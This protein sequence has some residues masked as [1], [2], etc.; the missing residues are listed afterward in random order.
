MLGRLGT[1]ISGF[2]NLFQHPNLQAYVN[3]FLPASVLPNPTWIDPGSSF[4]AG[5]FLRYDLLG[6]TGQMNNVDSEVLH[7]IFPNNPVVDWLYQLQQGSNYQF[8]AIGGLGAYFDDLLT[9]VAYMTDFNPANTATSLNLPLTYFSGERALMMTRSDWSTNALMLNMHTREFNGGHPEDDRNS[10]YIFGAGR[11]W[12]AINQQN[13]YNNA[14]S[15]VDI[16]APASTT[17]PIAGET[18]PPLQGVATPGRMVD[19]QD[20]PYATFAVGDASYCWDYVDTAGNGYTPAEIAAGDF[21]LPKGSVLEPHSKN[22]FA[23]TKLVSDEMNTPLSS[24]P[25]WIEYNGNIA[26]ITRVPLFA[27]PIVKAFRTTGLVRGPSTGVTPYGLVVDDI[28]VST[29]VAHHYDWQLLLVNDVQIMNQTSLPAS[30]GVYDIT[31]ATNGVANPGDPALLIRVLDMNTTCTISPC[32][33]YIIPVSSTNTR[34]DSYR[35]IFVIPS[36]SVSP[37]FKVLIFPYTIG[38]PIPT[39]TWNAAHT[40][41]TVTMPTYSDTITFSPAASGKT[42]VNIMRGGQTVI[43]MNTPIAPFQ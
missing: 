16:D 14:Q 6:G 7:Y 9:G 2:Q 41:V 11:G 33:P 30:E 21:K 26:P 10:I 22:S 3:K 27:T 1:S 19:F 42:D 5:P 25:S 20:Q 32:T 24:A 37:N 18:T 38:S 29:T 4:P 28:Q 40:A 12:T 15:I 39:T 35:P 43:N 13:F 23:Y 8:M 17:T 34:A 36:D 31:L